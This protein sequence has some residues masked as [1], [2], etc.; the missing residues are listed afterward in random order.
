MRR[1]IFTL[2][3]ISA[4][5]PALA[6]HGIV[7]MDG[8]DNTPVA[9]ATVIGKSGVILGMTDSR[10]RIDIDNLNNFPVTISCIGYEQASADADS[11]TLLLATSTFELNEVTVSPAER[12]VKR[13][14]C[15]AREYTSGITGRD[16]MQLYS[17]YMTEAFIVNG[18]VKG[19]KKG[20]AKPAVRTKR[21]YARI[22]KEG[23][24]S[25]FRPDAQ[26]DITALSWFDLMATLPDESIT[27]TEAIKSG[28]ET[29]TVPGKYGP[30]LT[31]RKKNN[32][33][34]VTTDMLSDHKNHTWSPFIF[35]LFG[36]TMDMEQVDM[37]MTFADTGND[38]LSVYDMVCGTYN[39]RII[40]RGKMFKKVFDTDQ[41]VE[42]NAYLEMYPID[43]ANI[44]VDEYKE[45]KS[46]A[47]PIAFQYPANL[48]PLSPAI[49]RLTA[50]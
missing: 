50:E 34:T 7:V 31:Y 40:G 41:P 4:L 20:D 5:L 1:L 8:S 32:L 12:P 6:G 13:V 10:G 19:Y 14:I 42:M 38:S 21:Q 48:Q 9:G 49:L 45:L 24:D 23:L 29:D 39:L 30:K 35:K 27:L 28:A 11:D 46:E 47:S 3:A 26:D 17:E 25:I 15:Y 36:L 44:T 43:I 18:K 16:T 37:S 22:A 2:A 33:L